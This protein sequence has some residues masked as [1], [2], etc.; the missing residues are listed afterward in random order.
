MSP[1]EAFD[2]LFLGAIWG[3]AFLF[4]RIAVPEFGPVAL[5]EVRVSVAAVLLLALVAAQRKLGEFKG[6]WLALGM[7]GTLNTA[8]PFVLFAF[9][10]RT[11]PAGFA[12]VLNATVPLFGAVFGTLFFG[13]RPR[14]MRTLGLAIGF[15]GVALLASQ[16][17]RVDG[18]ALAIAAALSAASMYAL[19]AHLT[20]RLLPG[21]P[22]LVVAAGSLVVSVVV[23]ALPAALTWPSTTPSVKAWGATMAL[24]VLATAV[25]NILY[26]RLLE[27]VGATGAM[28][29]TYLIPLFGMIWGWLFLN[30]VATPMMLIGCACILGGVAATAGLTNIRARR[31]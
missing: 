3:A 20:W 16:D 22:S 1:R 12:A 30:E 24:A 15:A 14:M 17:L 5:V 25:G 21:T 31:Q 2:L 23:L 11:V 4:T 19:S 7:I 28:A 18:G 8:V 9:A 10:T 29:V 26:F 13:E 27:R 6:R